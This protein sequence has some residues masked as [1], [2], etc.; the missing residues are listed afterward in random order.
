M[1]KSY[2]IPLPA[3]GVDVLSKET[4]LPKGAVRAAKN[5]D[6]S[7]DGSFDRRQG[8]TL[9]LAAGGMHSLFSAV[10]KGW[11]LGMQGNVLNRVDPD[12][13]ALTQL[14]T[15]ASTAPVEYVEYNGNIY[16]SSVDS[17][18]WIPSDS[19]AARALG[20]PAPNV[21]TLSAGN[22]TLAPGEYAV[23]VT[24][25]DDRGEQGAATEVRTI[26]L[27]NGGGIT[28]SGL[29]TS[30]TEVNIFITTAD[31]DVLRRAAVIPAVF[32]SYTVTNDATGPICTTQFME[33]MPPGRFVRWHNGRL[34]TARGGEMHFS[35]PFYPGLCSS[36]HGAKPLS[37]F[38]SMLEAVVGGIFVGD[39]RG[40]WFLDGGDP[41]D[42]KLRLASPVRAV[43][44]TSITVPPGFLGGEDFRDGAHALWLSTAGYM[45]GTPAGSVVEPQADKMRV[46][47]GLQGRS[48]LLQ[49]DGR[50]QVVTPVNSAATTA[51][52]A[53]VDSPTL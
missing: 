18:G 14:Y 16:F 45:I 6:I 11:L 4:A 29:P 52:G 44:G 49:R 38:A 24:M 12:T 42:A 39:S 53:V 47:L 33:P 34:Y 10:Q 5:V 48:A 40:V 41:S 32:A 15:M 8:Y 37:G 26:N 46:P 30:G 20:V 23:V 28:L 9:R 2:Q 19:S 17:I 7:R 22:G 25:T 35:E 36:A 31:G 43:P 3:R 27:L 51:F 21:P 50:K 13:Y 1:F